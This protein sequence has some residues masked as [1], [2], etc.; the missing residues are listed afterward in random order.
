MTNFLSFEDLRRRGILSSEINCLQYLIDVQ[1]LRPHQFCDQCNAYMEPKPCVATIYRDGYYWVCPTTPHYRSV[2][3]NSI[4]HNRKISFSSFLHLLWLFCNGASVSACAR[5]LS[6]NTKTVRS[7]YKA[8]RQCMAEDLMDQNGGRT[9]IDGPGHIIEIDES[10]FGKRKYN[11]GRRVVGKWI[12]GGY[13]QTTGD[14]F[15][16]EC[17]GNKR[18]HHTL[19]RLIKQNVALGTIILTEKWKGYNPFSSHGYTHLTVNHRRGFVDP[20]TG[21]HTN[22][23]EGSSTLCVRQVCAR[24]APGVHQACVCQ[25][26]VRSPVCARCAPD[27]RQA[28]IGVCARRAPG[29]LRHITNLP[30]IL[31]SISIC[32]K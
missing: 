10:K 25:V 9:K 11:R 18:D 30:Y 2:R 24:R 4:L 20:Q 6:K 14:C 13:C 23:C 3:T 15:L 27:V 5:I 12:L 28:C 29:V 1:I 19:L 8:L 16:V 21:V 32:G 7:L 26:C 22:T 31:T 17:P